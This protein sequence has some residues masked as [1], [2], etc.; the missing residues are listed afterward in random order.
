MR[1]HGKGSESVVVSV[2]VCA[3]A[4]VC[5][6]VCVRVRVCVCVCARVNMRVFVRACVCVYDCAR[7]CMDAWTWACA[8]E[9]VC[10]CACV[11]ACVSSC[12]GAPSPV[13]ARDDCEDHEHLH[14]NQKGPKATRPLT[15]AHACTRAHTRGHTP[16]CVRTH[17]IE[18][19]HARFAC[20]WRRS[21]GGLFPPIRKRH[22][23]AL[24]GSV[25][26]GMYTGVRRGTPGY[27]G[28][29]EIAACAHVI[30]SSP[31]GPFSC[32][33]YTSSATPGATPR[34]R[35]SAPIRDDVGRHSL[36]RQ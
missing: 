18:A 22:K 1:Q 35:R 33:T 25:L 8:C 29:A 27:A 31:S 26:W 24:L 30:H 5:A 14:L 36:R 23:R 13:A 16:A 11:G 20:G 12:G 6:C 9:S 17:T 15:R 19:A 3:C 7:V 28:T 32:A 4:C 2:C 21:V 10:V 34:T